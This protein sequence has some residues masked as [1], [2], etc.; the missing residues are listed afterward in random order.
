MVVIDDPKDGSVACGDIV[1]PKKLP[2]EVPDNNR[3]HDAWHNV[4]VTQ[5]EAEQIEVDTRGQATCPL[6]FKLKAHRITASDMGSI[7]L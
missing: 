2:I 6:W 1:L 7:M 5:Q 3:G 4:S